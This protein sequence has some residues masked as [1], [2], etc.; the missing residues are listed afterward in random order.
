MSVY[1]NSKGEILVGE[2]V[3][4]LDQLKMKVKER[5]RQNPK[6]V[7][8]LITDINAKY[9]YMIDALDEI[10]LAFDELKKENPEFKERISLATPAF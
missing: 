9:K 4:S 3:I 6:L 8:S 10:K 1:V 5:V 2:Q 7:V